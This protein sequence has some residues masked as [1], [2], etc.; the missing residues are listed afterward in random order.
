MSKLYI[1]KGDE[2]ITLLD[3]NEI[4]ALIENKE[5]ISNKVTTLSSLSTN[6]Q[7][8][9][10]KCVYDYIEEVIGEAIDYING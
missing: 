9:S 4:D 6:I 5:N 8:P 3:E 7:Y 10:A 2:L 1:K